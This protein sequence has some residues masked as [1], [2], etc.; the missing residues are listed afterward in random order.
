MSIQLVSQIFKEKLG[1]R[2]FTIS[3]SSAERA[4]FEKS[5]EVLQTINFVNY[6]VSGSSYLALKG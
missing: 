2:V 3:K 6:V 5:A 4:L 1:I